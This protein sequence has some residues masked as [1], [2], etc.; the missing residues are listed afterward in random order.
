MSFGTTILANPI[1]KSTTLEQSL[2]YLVLLTGAHGYNDIVFFKVGF[3]MVN[4]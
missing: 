3:E 1:I 4:D 2:P